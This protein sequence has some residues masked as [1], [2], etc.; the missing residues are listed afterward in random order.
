MEEQ[1]VLERRHSLR[2][3][4]SEEIEAILSHYPDKRS[5]L[6]PMLWLAQEHDGWI[7]E[8][9][10]AEIAHILEL[11]P[12]QV[13]G[14]GGFYHL[15]YFRPIGRHTVRVCDDLVCALKG[16]DGLLNH[17]CDKL[18]VEAG[19]TTHDGELTVE[20]TGWCVAACDH[21]PAVLLDDVYFG[22]VDKAQLD[23]M[24]QRLRDGWE[25]RADEGIEVGV[26]KVGAGS[27]DPG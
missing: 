1:Q 4:Y 7:S 2:E 14:V 20:R 17:V 9:R 23:E 16:A 11:D 18:D 19:E 10:V 22:P 5:A 15:F 12:T 26:V 8:R 25:P 6:L 13:R 3:L 24:I 21:A 27:G